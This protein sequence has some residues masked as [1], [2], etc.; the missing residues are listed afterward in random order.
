MMVNL[1]TI[2]LPFNFKPYNYQKTII[3]KIDNIYQNHPFNIC[4]ALVWGE[5]EEEKV[6]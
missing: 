5:P 4:R 2:H 6:L 1:E 3:D